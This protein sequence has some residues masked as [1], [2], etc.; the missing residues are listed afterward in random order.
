LYGTHNGFIKASG[1][2]RKRHS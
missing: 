2:H 1:V